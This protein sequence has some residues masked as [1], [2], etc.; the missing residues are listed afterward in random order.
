MENTADFHN[1]VDTDKETHIEEETQSEEGIEEKTQ[2]EEGTGGETHIEQ[3]TEEENHTEGYIVPEEAFRTE[4]EDYIGKDTLCWKC[5]DFH[6][7]D[8]IEG[9]MGKAH[10]MIEDIL[11]EGIAGIADIADTAGI[12]VVQTDP[13]V[14][15]GIAEDM[16]EAVDSLG[17]VD[18]GTDSGNTDSHIQH[19]QRYSKEGPVAL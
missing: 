17:N 11:W 5:E 6:S 12:L 8:S 7:L 2:F 9:Q 18:R 19:T 3:G 1:L 10:D 14:V 13:K 16:L 15:A 4:E